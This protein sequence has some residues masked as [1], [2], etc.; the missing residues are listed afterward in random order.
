MNFAEAPILFDCEGDCLVG[1]LTRPEQPCA[2]GVVVV[3]GGPQYRAGSHR[4]FT[5]LSRELG[6]QGIA[7]LRFDVRGM[8]DS[9]GTPRTFEQIDVDIACATA[10]LMRRVPTVRQ[11]VLWGLCDGASA[12]I[13]AVERLTGIAGVVA[14]NPWVRSETSHDATLIKHYYKR[15]LLSSE[16]WIRLVTGKLAIA[17]AAREFA[18]RFATVA[19]SRLGGAATRTAAVPERYQ[20]RM[21]NG[22]GNFTGRTMIVLSGKDLTAQEFKAFSDADAGWKN[23]TNTNPHVVVEQLPEADHTMSNDTWRREV[24]RLTCRFVLSLLEHNV[25]S[26]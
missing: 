8:G 5:L 17:R 10:E 11:V 23:A 16:F 13:M 14:L 6:E 24:E 4:Q 25:A 2:V 12:A 3:V 26:R 21:S 18:K 9:E 19:I 15:R 20:D 7:C 22:L 1:C